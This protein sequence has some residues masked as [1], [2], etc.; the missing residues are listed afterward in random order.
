[1]LASIADQLSQDLWDS[2]PG[3]VLLKCLQ[4]D[5]NVLLGL[6][7]TRNLRN[8]CCV[9]HLLVREVRLCR[10][11]ISS[12]TATRRTGCHNPPLIANSELPQP[13]TPDR[14]RRAATYTVICPQRSKG[15]ASRVRRH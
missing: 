2:D 6:R 11:L 4:C 14:M 9:V 1:M 12:L 5:F 3:I 8:K 15:K 10:R 7:T 13:I